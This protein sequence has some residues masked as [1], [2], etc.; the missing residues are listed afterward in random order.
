MQAHSPHQAKYFA[1]E[2][3]KRCPSDSVE[4][5]STALVDAQVD[6]NPHQVEAALF[7]FRSPL[8]AGAILA[9]EV[10]LGKTIE[11]G[12][13]LSQKWAE[14][15]RRLLVIC[16]SNLRKQWA[17]EL[18]DKFFLPTV[19]LEAKNF[20]AWAQAGR[21]NP[22]EQPQIVICSFHFAHRQAAYLQL[23]RWDLA[24]IDEA[25]R[26]R[27]AYQPSNKIGKSIKEALAPVPKVLL[28]ATPLQN[29]LMEL[30][31]LVSLI[32]E[33][34]FGDRFSFR[35]QFARAEGSYNF[36]DLRDRLAP[37][38]H[39]TL[40]RQVQEYIRY[41]NRLPL[42]IR[43][44]PTAEEHRLYEV[45]NQYLQRELLYALP[46]SQRHLITLIMR[47]LLASSSFA[48]SGTLNGLIRR[49]ENLVQ[50]QEER[51]GLVEE[52]EEDLEG[53]E[54]LLDE[55]E[56]EDES[57]EAPAPLT[58]E[59]IEAVQAEIAELKAYRD[60]AERIQDN[61][62][63]EK[64]LIAL[65]EGF[66]KLRELGAPEKAIVFTESRRTQEYLFRLL[67]REG[68]A[69]KAVLFNGSNSDERSRHIYQ[70]WLE[71]Q[72]GSD[73]VSG[74]PSADKRAAIVDYFRETAQVMIATEAAAEG[75]NLQFCA[76]VVNYD[77]PWNPQRIE[78]RIG[79][80]HRYG[81]QHDVAVVNFL[82]LK[83]AADQRVFQLLDE[84]FQLFSGV[85][86]ASDD[87]LGTIESGVDFEKKIA[88][89]YQ[90]CRTTE[91]I[92]RSFDALQ[93]ELEE[94]INAR[95]KNARE[96]LFEYFDAE[97]IDKLK[98]RLEDTKSYISKYEQWLW[99]IAR[100]ALQ[101]FAA[102][103]LPRFLFQLQRL[104][105]G[106][107]A[108]LGWY[109]LDKKQSAPH[110]LRI[111]HP[112][113]QA[114]IRQAKEA[115]TPEASIAFNYSGARSAA[116]ILAPLAGK[117]GYLQ[118]D[119]MTVLSFET[120]DHLLF[121]AMDED[122]AWLSPEQCQRLLALEPAHW[123]PLPLPA[124]AQ[125]A[126][127]E[128][129]AHRREALL[130]ELRD[131]DAAYFRHETAKLQKWADDRILAAEKAIRDT[132]AKIRELERQANA[133]TDMPALLEL[134][135]KI[136]ELKKKQRRQRTEVFEVEDKIELQRDAMI[137]EIELR[138][139]RKTIE[140]TLFAIRWQ[141][142]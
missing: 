48:I 113:A 36:E 137:R 95:I 124:A 92:N 22:F 139:L 59:E 80:C 72:A 1:Y 119:L 5:L 88:A 7:A 133:E 142:V 68:Y 13:L 84:K 37:L 94:Q 26:L 30:Y 126:L 51:T 114:I 127:P 74:S 82:N 121:T 58:A 11:A 66:Q 47:K 122:G 86:G 117:S 29:S 91:E 93:Q 55:W 6:L 108:P 34:I 105:P 125:K 103:D 85:F 73:L 90:S 33:H 15:K 57:P 77:L 19:I 40:R 14:E 3:T 96:Q 115:P 116:N 76:M 16:P 20:N 97:V 136:A 21:K 60:L 111:G 31:G 120:T 67:E 10:G 25:H 110:R 2:L 134:Q 79:R 130:D 45:V 123:A 83:N 106:V 65:R 53:L 109:T 4:K 17:Q 75:I 99:H 35:A 107:Q 41:T 78:Q 38:C 42:T 56:E 100:Y 135:K 70:A 104:P 52:L 98:I 18:A 24:V 12:I 89:I 46:S 102:F 141:L 44:E 118:L 131:K 43:F 87:V 63:G 128:R 101:G 49:L 129:Y 23:A 32:D 69:G 54:D 138:M 27:N 9:D 50:E 81:Q 132:K 28:T 39:R 71:R 64:L 61:A 140:S 62:K 112:L 8:S